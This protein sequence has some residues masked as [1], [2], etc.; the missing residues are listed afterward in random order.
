[1]GCAA[2][3][4]W[5]VPACRPARWCAPKC[6]PGPNPTASNAVPAPDADTKGEVPEEVTGGLPVLP[7]PKA[8][9]V[10]GG[11]RRIGRALVLTLAE[12]GFAVAIHHH[13]SGTEA[14]ALAN[15][16]ARAGGKA[17]ALA[18][19]LTDEA[20]VKRLL[21]E[22][23][24]ALGPVGVLVNNASIFGNDTVATVTRESW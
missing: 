24:A 21:P 4:P 17:V 14:E 5:A 23:A 11:A 7:I 19:D 13:R 15:E 18:A 12:A 8:A 10:T 9:L 2:A 22:A 1:M 20:A 6:A 16:I 3:R